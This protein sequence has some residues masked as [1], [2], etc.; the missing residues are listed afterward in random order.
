MLKNIPKSFTPELLKL[1]MEMGHGEDIL[2]ADGNFPQ[3]SMNIKTESIYMPI[4]SITELLRD[5]LKFFPLDYA[6]EA[7]AF[8]MESLTESQRYGEYTKLI[9]E[10]GSK[11]AL[12]ER[13]K[14]YELAKNAVGIIVTSDTV[15]GGNILIRKGV[16]KDNEV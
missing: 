16:V 14:F 15:K 9:E 2:I 6:V 12:A 8:A 5:I 13:F 3:K 4:C 10:N 7:A 1:L 11:L